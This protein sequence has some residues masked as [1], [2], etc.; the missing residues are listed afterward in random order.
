MNSSQAFMSGGAGQK[1][2]VLSAEIACSV[3]LAQLNDSDRIAELAGQLGYPCTG[4]DVRKRLAEMQESKQ[5]VVFVAELPGG[6]VV[7]WIGAYIFRSIEL[8]PFA[9]INGLIVDENFRSHRVG[10]ILLKAAEEWA[11]RMGST[12]VSVHSNI[13]RERAHR[14]YTNDGYELVKTQRIFRKRL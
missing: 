1:C 3:R 8:D 9:E 10:K 7:G 6:Q 4:S 13:V 2:R 5:D 11:R 14:F 12:L